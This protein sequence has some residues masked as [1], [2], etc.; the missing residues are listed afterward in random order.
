MSVNAVGFGGSVSL[1]STL[2][3]D[4][5]VS[6]VPDAWC[7]VHLF[8]S[9]AND[10]DVDGVQ[11]ELNRFDIFIGFQWVCDGVLTAERFYFRFDRNCLTRCVRFNDI[12]EVVILFFVRFAVCCISAEKVM[13]ASS[14]QMH[15]R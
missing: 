5:S 14:S 12:F 7:L 2:F 10:L 15:T 11:S 9:I 6:V 8:N 3:R 4:R 1:C 13:Q